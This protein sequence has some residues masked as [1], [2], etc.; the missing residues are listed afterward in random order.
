[1]AY[2]DKISSNNTASPDAINYKPMT[3]E[4][5][6]LLNGGALV[7]MLELG[8]L[9]GKE[10]LL[11][12]LVNATL[13]KNTGSC[14]EYRAKSFFNE[15]KGVMEAISCSAI[16]AGFPMTLFTICSNTGLL[17]D[18][19]KVKFLAIQTQDC[20]S[21][22]YDNDKIKLFHSNI[23]NDARLENANFAD[24]EIKGQHAFIPLNR[25]EEKYK[26]LQDIFAGHFWDLYS[27]GKSPGEKGFNKN[28]K[29]ALTDILALS[30]ANMLHT[31][32][33]AHVP[34][35]ALKGLLIYSDKYETDVGY[36]SSS[37]D[38]YGIMLANLIREKIA[39]EKNISLPILHYHSN[40]KI[41][42]FSCDFQAPSIKEVKVE[43]NKV[44]NIL[45][46]NP[47]TK[48]VYERFLGQ[49]YVQNIILGR[50]DGLE[51][52]V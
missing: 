49:E 22:I 9:P 38:L 28:I 37:D 42:E 8:V 20:H 19:K 1:M 52:E 24:A 33:L 7:H 47:Y 44:A 6:E 48:K 45:E 12:N 26:E 40:L 15:K 32:I 39:L 10:E 17:I 16:K 14:S 46:T 11:S 35:D 36:K 3:P 31:E 51:R 50:I 41:E 23:F 4:V 34:P 21:L 2:T 18:P 13:G 25:P 43:N 5:D 27:G 29:N 30:D